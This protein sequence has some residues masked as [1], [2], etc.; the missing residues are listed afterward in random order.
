M[1][2]LCVSKERKKEVDSLSDSDPVHQ[3]DSLCWYKYL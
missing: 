3:E 1:K 2:Q